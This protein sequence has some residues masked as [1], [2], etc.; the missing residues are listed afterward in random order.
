[1]RMRVSMAVPRLLLVA[2]AALA[3]RAW[4]AETA[5]DFVACGNSKIT[6]LEARAD[7]TAFGVEL[8]GI[9]ATSTTK[10][11]ENATQHCLGTMRVVEGK[12]TGRGMCKWT[13]PGGNT[14]V[15][16]W[17]MTATGE[18]TWTFLS[19][20]GRFKGIKG[21][22]S[23]Q[24]LSKAKPIVDG[25]AQSCRRDRGTYSLPTPPA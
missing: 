17:E 2:V 19:G 22:G 12:Q 1:M 6:M 3:P 11:L 24:Y 20:T 7:L 9:V 14:F 21:A 5:Y 8:L 13:D 25:T 18:G 10:D 23:F 16:E 15:G 4:G